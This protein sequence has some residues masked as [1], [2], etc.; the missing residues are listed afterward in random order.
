MA[1]VGDPDSGGFDALQVER[2]AVAPERVQFRDFRAL[3]AIA[4]ADLQSAQ[5]GATG[6]NLV[7]LWSVAAGGVCRQHLHRVGLGLCF[8]MLGFVAPG[9]RHH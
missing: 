4:R 6:R 1:S 7:P 5:V 2:L 8:I 9:T 3:E